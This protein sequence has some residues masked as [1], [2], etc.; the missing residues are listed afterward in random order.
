MVSRAVALKSDKTQEHV[1]PEYTKDSNDAL[2]TAMYEARC[3]DREK[4]A[5][6]RRYRRR[7][8]YMLTGMYILYI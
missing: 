6:K 2:I 8:D 5:W 3:Q 7:F 1:L 4:S